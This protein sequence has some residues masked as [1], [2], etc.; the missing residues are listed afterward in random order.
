MRFDIGPV[1]ANGSFSGSANIT[2]NPGLGTGQGTGWALGRL[3]VFKV[4]WPNRTA[5]LFKD[6]DSYSKTG[7]FNPNFLAKLRKLRGARLEAFSAYRKRLDPNG[8]FYNEFLR[9]LLE[10]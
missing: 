2:G 9:N 1:Q 7:P 10:L 3:F 8:L 6:P 4:D 5:H